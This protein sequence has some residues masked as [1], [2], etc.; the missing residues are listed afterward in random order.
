MKTFHIAALFAFAPH[1]AFAACNADNVLRALQN[2]AAKA[3]PFCSTY[4]LPPPN[5]PLPTYVSQS[6]NLDDFHDQTHDNIHDLVLVAFEN[7]VLIAFENLDH[8]FHLADGQL[9]RNGDFETTTSASEAPPWEFAQPVNPN[10][11]QE[12]R[13]TLVFDNDTNYAPVDGSGGYGSTYIRQPI[14]DLCKYVYYT[15]SFDAKTEV[16]SGYSQ[17]GC[18]LEINLNGRQLVYIAPGGS[19][20]LPYEYQR[21]SYTFQYG[22]CAPY[23]VSCSPQ[24]LTI[25]FTCEAPRGSFLIDNISL[26]GAGEYAP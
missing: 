4:T 5:Q 6:D 16:Y 25:R 1:G 18:T 8:N 7:L 3:S 26:V 2:N 15:F 9:I 13:A 20:Y 22:G 14:P 24:A 12:S 21:R 11:G 23:G 19:E 17:R 10:S